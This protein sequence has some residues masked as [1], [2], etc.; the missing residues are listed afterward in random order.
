MSFLTH[1][2]Y[3]AYSAGMSLATW[4]V[5]V[6]W[7]LMRA[8]ARETCLEELNQRLGRVRSQVPKAGPRILIHA[9]S[10][11]EMVAADVLVGALVRRI[12]R[13]QVILTSGNRYGLEAGRRV[14]LKHPE[15]REV[16][17]L[18][19]DRRRSLRHWLRDLRPDLV[20]VVETELWPNLF[21]S[22][23]KLGIKLCLVN[24]RIYPRDLA[25]YRL[26]SRFLEPALDCVT[27]F[28]V[29]SDAEKERFCQIGADPGRIGVAANLKFDAALEPGP[30]LNLSLAGRLIIVAGSTHSPEEAWIFDAVSILRRDFPRLLL[31][32]APR[33]PRRTPSIVSQAVRRGL[34]V[35]RYSE[36]ADGQVDADVLIL[37]RI[38]V[39]G[40]LYQAADVTII[41][42]SLAKYGGHNLLEPAACACSI[43]MGPH[44]EHFQDIVDD[45]RQAGAFVL[46][47]DRRQ[48]LAG[49]RRLLADSSSREELGEKARAV[50]ESRAGSADQYADRIVALLNLE[51]VLPEAIDKSHDDELSKAFRG[52][53]GWFLRKTASDPSLEVILEAP[54]PLLQGSDKLYKDSRSSTVGNV[55]GY[56]IKRYNLRRPLKWVKANLRG[57]Y[58]RRAFRVAHQL[59]LAGI[60]GARPVA[61]GDRR[62]WG[63]VVGSYLVTREIPGA[64]PLDRSTGHPAARLRA[65]ARLFGR[66]HEQGFR[67]LDPKP[68]NILVD[69]AGAAHLVDMDGVLFVKRV[70]KEVARDDLNEFLARLALGSADRGLFVRSYW[71]AR[72]FESRAMSGEV[73]P[74]CERVSSAVPPAEVGR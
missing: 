56:V 47:P 14:Q 69:T 36:I 34:S 17:L 50:V 11:G 6:P 51:R 66:L 26:A 55:A 40:G 68:S 39:L 27:R 22:C 18:P 23:G 37:D 41:G 74:A 46:L 61:F 45:F 28:W 57:S 60:P 5:L 7:T 58:A 33:H 8:S 67:Q 64:T 25:S 49:L 1:L 59:E 13:I 19:W 24:G 53:I 70:P 44:F 73:S 43:V 12:P 20:A 29:Q 62:R 15:V 52:N 4:L 30:G 42:G 54:D 71:E 38:G 10:V 3:I 9:V 72:G 31:V 21:L 32:V 35:A 63:M 65:V 2:L 16:W 48:L